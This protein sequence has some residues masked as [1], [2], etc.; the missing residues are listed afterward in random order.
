M[1]ILKMKEVKHIV[2]GYGKQASKDFLKVLDDSVH[3]QIDRLV[4]NS[5]SK[6]LSEADVTYR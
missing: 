3:R 4:S 1:S 2:K 6:R 5:R